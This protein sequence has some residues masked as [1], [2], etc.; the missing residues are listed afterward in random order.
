MKCEWNIKQDSFGEYWRETVEQGACPNEATVVIG[1][2]Q[3][4]YVCATCAQNRKLKC[5][6]QRP[7]NPPKP[8]EA[9][10]V[11]RKLVTKRRKKA[12]HDVALG[13]GQSQGY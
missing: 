5:F 13:E 12:S 10:Q 9:K 4:G 7:M 6:F 11:V 1:R 2:H 8:Q 3:W